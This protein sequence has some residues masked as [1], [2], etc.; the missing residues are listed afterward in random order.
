[1]TTNKSKYIFVDGVMKINPEYKSADQPQSTVADPSKAIAIV[2]STQDIQTAS[3]AQQAS[4]GQAMQLS[5]ATTASM[6]IMQDRD[7]LNQF[8]APT[9]LDGGDLLDGLSNIFAKH[10]IPIG[11]INKL[12]A[13]SEYKLNFII[14][15][16]GSMGNKSDALMSQASMQVKQQCDRDCRRTASQ[17]TMTRWEEAQ[18]RLHVMIDILAYIPTGKISITFL[19]RNTPITL[20]HAGKTPDMFAQD[21][22]AQISNAF[23]ATPTGGTPIYGALTK[24][25]VPSGQPTMHY[26]F[27]DGEPSDATQEQVG[28][29]VLRRANPKANPL[30]FITCTNDSTQA[31]WMKKIEGDA[32]Y[33]SELDDFFE[34]RKEVLAA[35]GPGFP[36]NKGLW[37]ICQLVAA[38]NP[39]DLDALDEK[40]PFTKKTMDDLMGRKLTQQEYFRYF[41]SNPNAVQYRQQYLQFAREDIIAR[42]VLRNMQGGYQSNAQHPLPSAPAQAY[43]QQPV[44]AQY[45]STQQQ[46][47]A[48]YSTAQG[49]TMWGQ[50]QQSQPAYASGAQQPVNQYAPSPYRR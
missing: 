14:D 4:T 29:L 35:Q 19:N 41:D 50:Q 24:S 42:D 27:T 39:I 36:F 9:Q 26:L 17:D 31:E 46:P 47:A 40:T 18:D 12:L 37:L 25:F 8:H 23:R 13:L 34:E 7:F 32:E 48:T 15:D 22:H 5:S 1:M 28:E 21:A 45:T 16:S 49:Q 11:L 20:D 2:S 43:G 3:S 44:Q 30:A 10:E 33:T 38:I 6:E